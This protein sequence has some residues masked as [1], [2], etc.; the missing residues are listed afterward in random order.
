MRAFFM[1][2][3]MLVSCS[4]AHAALSHSAPPGTAQL[5]FSFSAP[6][7]YRVTSDDSALKIIF[8]NT[9]E[10]AVRQSISGILQQNEVIQDMAIKPMADGTVVV[11]CALSE[12]DISVS[13]KRFSRV[14][15]L[16]IDIQRN[17]RL[18]RNDSAALLDLTGSV[19]V[20]A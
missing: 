17:C 14:H 3:C 15:H 13:C 11:A 2:A 6:F 10:E 8:N 20:T 7:S 4:V 16:V 1:T 5:F 19:F 12:G 9:S 18:S